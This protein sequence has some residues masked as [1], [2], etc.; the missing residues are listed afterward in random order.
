MDVRRSSSNLNQEDYIKGFI[1][2]RLTSK[3]SWTWTV[4]KQEGDTTWID[5]LTDV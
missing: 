2:V 4:N 5:N 1:S 3:L